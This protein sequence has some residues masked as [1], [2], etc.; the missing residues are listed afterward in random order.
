[1]NSQEL[2]VVENLSDPMNDE[3]HYEPAEITDRI[4]RVRAVCQ[5]VMTMDRT[6]I[7]E[8]VAYLDPAK[9]DW[10]SS[11]YMGLARIS[12]VW[13][14]WGQSSTKNPIANHQST[15]ELGLMLQEYVGGVP[16]IG[17]IFDKVYDDLLQFTRNFLE[18]GKVDRFQWFE[19]VEIEY[20][21]MDTDR[22]VV[23]ISNAVGWI[24]DV[25]IEIVKAVILNLCGLSHEGNA[26]YLHKP[27][28]MWVGQF[29]IG[30]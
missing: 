14:S 22:L 5:P 8:I 24:W 11:D 18:N 23:T 1:M 15:K 16:R 6:R 17:L 12:A 27:V 2:P 30:R 26:T 19:R 10:R 7:A 3:A 25:D 29:T 13:Q 4:K 21:K 28:A 20:D 9:K